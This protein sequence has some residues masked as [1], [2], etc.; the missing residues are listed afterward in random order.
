MTPQPKDL[1]P[2]T[3]A[4][5]IAATPQERA[6]SAEQFHRL[7]QVPPEAEWFA[8]I[9]NPSTRRA[10]RIDVQDFSRFVG[11]ERAEEFRIVTR[12]HVIAWRDNL[13]HRELSPATI[14][15]KLSAIGSLFD[16]LLRL[17]LRLYFPPA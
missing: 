3:P 4:K 5:R 12:A 11:I 13:K 17:K 10:Y 7:A 15:R 16:Y 1:V 14:R 2:A 9:T 6:L 8:N